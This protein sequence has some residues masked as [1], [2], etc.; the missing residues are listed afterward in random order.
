MFKS[1][2][3]VEETPLIVF[4]H[5]DKSAVITSVICQCEKM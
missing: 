2:L 4:E 5:V 1:D 3:L